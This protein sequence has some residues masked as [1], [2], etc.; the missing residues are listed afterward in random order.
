MR[1]VW[2]LAFVGVF[3]CKEQRPPERVKVLYG[4]E[5]AIYTAYVD[6]PL[7]RDKA[8]WVY[9]GVNFTQI[10]KDAPDARE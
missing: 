8:E 1:M 3:G 9:D 4:Y 6:E 7:W 10:K 2:L 5:G